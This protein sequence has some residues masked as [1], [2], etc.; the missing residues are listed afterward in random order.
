MAV[1]A[2][3]RVGHALDLGRV[4]GRSHDD[5][6]V[7]HDGL[8]IHAM[9]GLH[10]GLLGGRGVHQ[11]HVSVA[12][13]AELEGLTAAHRDD[14]HRVLRV[15]L[16]ERRDED[17]EEARVLRRGGR[18]QDEVAL[19][20][21]R[22]GL[23]C[24]CGGRRS[25]RR[26]SR[27]RAGFGRSRGGGLLVAATCGHEDRNSQDQNQRQHERRPVQIPVVLHSQSLLLLLMYGL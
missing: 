7:V 17:V 24:G 6:V 10:E 13:L 15:D 22:A 19:S 1:K 4:V 18:G 3:R 20:D 12:G 25:R 2:S 11:Q 27:C 8:A 16:V 23:R 9:T 5:E 14:L 26:R 21:S